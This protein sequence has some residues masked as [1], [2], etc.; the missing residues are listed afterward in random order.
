MA[1]QNISPMTAR[2]QT[3][4]DKKGKKGKKGKAGKGG[5]ALGAQPKQHAAPQPEGRLRKRLKSDKKKKQ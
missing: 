4:G 5:A 1:A 3:K 2:S